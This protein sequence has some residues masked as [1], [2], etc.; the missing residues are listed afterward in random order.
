ME[1]SER[2]VVCAANS[3]VA[4]D[5]LA[6]NRVLENV[7]LY[8]Q[9]AHSHGLL[10]QGI[11]TRR[12]AEQAQE[13]RR[14]V[15]MSLHRKAPFAYMRDRKITGSSRH[16]LM[17]KLFGDQSYDRCVIREHVAYL[18]SACSLICTDAMCSQWL[19]DEQFAASLFLYQEAY[20]DYYSAYCD[21]LLDPENAA[22]RSTKSLL[23][24]LRHQ[25]KQIRTQMVYGSAGDT[26]FKQ[27]Q[28]WRAPTGDTQRLTAL[29]LTFSL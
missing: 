24:Y 10:M 21:C 15:F 16:L 6:A 18:C 28:Q 13:L 8:Q 26:D 17:S 2:Q 25:L 20:T 23:P 3:D 12:P 5:A 19:S 4:A 11:A 14:T 1:Y 22:S 29:P 9:W 27:L 7:A